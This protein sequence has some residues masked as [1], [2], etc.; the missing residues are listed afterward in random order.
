MALL[1]QTTDEIAIE[2]ARSGK[3]GAPAPAVEAPVQIVFGFRSVGA[4]KDVEAIAREHCISKFAPEISFFSVAPFAGGHLFECHEGGSGVAYLPEVIRELSL[5][6]AAGEVYV[7]SGDRLFCIAMRDGHPVCLKLSESE[8]KIALTKS[9]AVF[10]KPTG[11]MKPAVK[12]GDGFVQVGTVLMVFGAISLFASIGYYFV[13]T[14]GQQMNK[15]VAYEQLPHRQW[16]SI[17]RL[18]TD[19]YVYRLR[20]SDGR[21]QIDYA[22]NP[23]PPS[24]PLPPRPATHGAVPSEAVP[25]PVVPPPIAVP[26]SDAKAAMGGGR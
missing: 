1:E 19:Q 9:T 22:D 8:S 5:N 24:S 16:D 2:P 13:S 18:R 7:P 3:A 10:P 14:S 25:P 21:W 15:S 17:R 6:M 23:K 4:I 12:A 11:K 26:A 20:Y